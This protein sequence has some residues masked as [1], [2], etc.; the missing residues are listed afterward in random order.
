M[1]TQILRK[2]NSR[3][4]LEHRYSMLEVVTHAQET[5]VMEVEQFFEAIEDPLLNMLVPIV[6]QIAVDAM[7][8]TLVGG[9][10]MALPPVLATIFAMPTQM[11]MAGAAAA[12]D[13]GGLLGGLF[14][15]L[16]VDEDAGSSVK[17]PKRTWRRVDEIPQRVRVRSCRSSLCFRPSLSSTHTHTHTQHRLE[18]RYPQTREERRCINLMLRLRKNR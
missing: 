13:G 11:G 5:T 12:F 17:K 1:H 9:L 7:K 16:E 15:F 4:A 6:V 14:G 3:F 2:L 18:H 8:P 10:C